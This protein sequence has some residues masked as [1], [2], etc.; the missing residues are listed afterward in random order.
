MPGIGEE[1]ATPRR[2]SGGKGRPRPRRPIPAESGMGRFGP[3]GTGG[4]ARQLSTLL[5][6][7]QERRPG[8]G[9]ASQTG[10]PRSVGPSTHETPAPERVGRS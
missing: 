7:Q 5:L 4:P 3:A 8:L 1:E 6:F 10:A 9:G 2:S